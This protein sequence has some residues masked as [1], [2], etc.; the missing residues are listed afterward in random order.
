MSDTPRSE[1]FRQ[2]PLTLLADDFIHHRM[3][4]RRT[5]QT[6]IGPALSTRIDSEDVLQESWV[7]ASQRV[8]HLPESDPTTVFLW[9]RRIVLQTLT[10]MQRRH[11]VAQRRSVYREKSLTDPAAVSVGHAGRGPQTAS[12]IAIRQETA[13]LIWTVIQGMREA[14]R[15]VL[16]LR[17][18]EELS[19][20]EVAAV[21][22]LRKSA[23]S[24]RYVRA[25]ARLNEKLALP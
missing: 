24:N 11:A 6:R 14:D 12:A 20:D 9:L 22:G 19:N 23:A 4:L 10:D 25:L 13:D 1:R 5:I 2:S 3:R 8:R 18:Y 17:H 16:T 21:L 7:A 15:E